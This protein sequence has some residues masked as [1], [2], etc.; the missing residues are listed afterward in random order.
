[1][2]WSQ[3][4]RGWPNPTAQ[5]DIAKLVHY[6]LDKL[7]IHNMSVV[8][9]ALVD[10]AEGMQISDRGADALLCLELGHA[11]DLQGLINHWSPQAAVHG[12]SVAPELLAVQLARSEE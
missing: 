2:P 9:Y 3:L 12:L 1:M 7:P 10:S 5:H 8:W 4:M 11:T 6:L